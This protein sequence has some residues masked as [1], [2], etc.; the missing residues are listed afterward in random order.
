MNNFERGGD[1]LKTMGVGKVKVL[2]MNLE[3]MKDLVSVERMHCRKTKELFDRGWFDGVLL[4]LELDLK[5]EVKQD[6]YEF[7][8]EY[9][10]PEFFEHVDVIPNMGPMSIS[11]EDLRESLSWDDMEELEKHRH[12]YMASL[13]VKPE[14]EKDFP[15]F[16]YPF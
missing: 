6:I 4:Y 2:Q 12:K 5:Y 10:D 7:L 15:L 16:Y 8:L 3:K 11:M 1:V 9:L 14:Y 13:Y